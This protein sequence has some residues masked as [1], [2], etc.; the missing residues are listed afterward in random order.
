MGETIAA[1]RLASAFISDDFPVLYV[2]RK[3]KQ[4]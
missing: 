1:G 2:Y 3:E 4:K